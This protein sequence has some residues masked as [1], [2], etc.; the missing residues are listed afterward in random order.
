MG[1]NGTPRGLRLLCKNLN[2]NGLPS[3]DSLIREAPEIYKTM[4]A[5]ANPI[6]CPPK[7]DNKILLRTLRAWVTCYREAKL[8]MGQKLPSCWLTFTVQ[9]DVMQ[10]IEGELSSVVSGKPCMQQY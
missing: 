6:V 3:Y 8:D 7:R 10:V 9:E 2:A 1:G 4:Q 5:I